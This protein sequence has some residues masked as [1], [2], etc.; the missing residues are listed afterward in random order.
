MLPCQEETS[1]PFITTCTVQVAVCPSLVVAV[2]TALPK[3]TPVTVFPIT[4]ATPVSLDVRTASLIMHPITEAVRDALSPTLKASLVLSR[5]I[6][7]E[8]LLVSV[9]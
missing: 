6:V 1:I 8:A 4:E 3:L 9:A 5:V 2:I 7:P